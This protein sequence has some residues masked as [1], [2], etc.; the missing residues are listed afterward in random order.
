MFNGKIAVVGCG[1]GGAAAALLLQQ[2]GLDFVVYEQAPQFARMGAGIH[3]TPNVMRVLDSVEVGAA[4]AASGCC[5]A[6]FT[7]RDAHTG[8]LLAVQELGDS[9]RQRYGAPYLTVHRGDFH[10]AMVEKI[11]PGRVQ[12]GKRLTS[13]QWQGGPVRL[14]FA[15]GT[16]E[17]ADLVIG[18]DGLSSVVRSLMCSDDPPRFAGQAAFRALVD[19]AALAEPPADDVTKWWSDERFIIAYY[20]TRQRDQ[21]YFVAGFPMASWPAGTPSLPA[22]RDEMLSIFADFHPS[23]RATL[24]GAQEVRKWPLYEREPEPVWS[25][26]PVVVLG[27]AC[28]PMR[29]HMAQG[30]AMAIEDAAVLVRCLSAQGSDDWAPALRQY[31]AIRSGR[32][33]L[34]QAISSENS[35]MRTPTDPS[36]VFEYD[37]LNPDTVVVDPSAPHAR[38]T[39]PA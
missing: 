12:R 16:S 3:L 34:V 10:A 30:A 25:K 31:Q 22:Q 6:K 4:L 17:R 21:Y 1:L 32:T 9:A 26:G 2:A 27:D 29:P 23:A 36:W 35:W 13:L 7:S 37:A 38:R 5:P 39:V 20:L 14:D 11:G 15:D 19:P 18:A 8:E 24:A 28:H 33:A